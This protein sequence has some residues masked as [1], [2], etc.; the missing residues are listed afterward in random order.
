MAPVLILGAIGLY[1]KV[2]DAYEKWVAKPDKWRS[3]LGSTAEGAGGLLLVLL[4]G[5]PMLLL[6]LAAYVAVIFIPLMLLK[7]IF[8]GD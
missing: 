5:V 3:L 2:S 4:V 8:F 1:A 6:R 7:F